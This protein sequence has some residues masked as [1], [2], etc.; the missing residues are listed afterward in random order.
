MSK[1]PVAI[2]SVGTIVA[3]FIPRYSDE[4][5]QLGKVINI[6]DDENVE[7]EW[8]IGSYAEPWRIW[9]EKKGKEYVTWKDI[10][11]KDA[12]LFPVALSKTDRLLSSDI[13]R[14]KIAYV[15]KRKTYC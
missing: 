13:A 7:V 3:C 6:G 8:M 4:E 11:P 2:L 1:P 10:I 12:I 14:L 15:E 9:K 5:P